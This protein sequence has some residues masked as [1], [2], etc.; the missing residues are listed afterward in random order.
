[1]AKSS[2]VSPVNMGY[3]G[4]SNLKTP[5]LYTRGWGAVLRLRWRQVLVNYKF[6]VDLIAERFYNINLPIGGV[7]QLVRTPA[8]HAG[9]RRFESVRPRHFSK[10]SY[11]GLIL[12]VFKHE[13]TGSNRLCSCL[14]RFGLGESGVLR[15]WGN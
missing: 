11:L 15:R 2:N 4:K 14:S 7:V 10:H 8:C 13:T 1:M 5:H 12:A 6:F 9:G 3:V